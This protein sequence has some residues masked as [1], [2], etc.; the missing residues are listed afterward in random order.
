MAQPTGTTTTI[1][2]V[3]EAVNERGVK[4]NRLAVLKAAAAFAAIRPEAKSTDVLI[5]ADKWLAWV[6]ADTGAPDA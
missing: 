1:T 5:V 6:L 4:V 3:V 2:G